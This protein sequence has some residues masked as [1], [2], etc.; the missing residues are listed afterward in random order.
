[1]DN[2]YNEILQAG[3]ELATLAGGCFWCMVPPFINLPGV[4]KVVSGYTG[5]DKENPTYKEVCNGATGHLEAIQ[6]TFE[7]Q[8]IG[9]EKL[10]EI[11]WK[12]ID[13]T[14]A[15]GQ[16]AD[17]GRSYRTAIFYHNESQRLAAEASKEAINQSHRFSAP[18][19][20]LI[21]P[22]RT[23][24]SAEDYH[25]DYFKKNPVHYKKY[26][27]GSGREAFINFQWAENTSSPDPASMKDLA[28]RLSKIQFDVTQNNATEPPFRNEYWDNKR[29]GIYVDVVS[30]QVLFSSLNKYDS[31][32]GWPSFTRPLKEDYVVEKSDLS[33]GMRRIEV[34]S[35]Q[36][37]SHLGHVFND[38]PDPSGL[39]YCINSAALRFIPLEEM[40]AFG[41]GDYL[42][43]FEE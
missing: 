28:K 39:R 21:L 43:I 1:M 29:A 2:Q 3:E 13:P 17:R 11:F 7:P 10:L 25:Q 27:T 12:Q 36:A 16:F 23:F 6:L 15:G 31:G 34:K 41:Y 37:D 40:K 33:Q 5:G 30:G 38:G 19:A 24:Y 26:R 22:A 14:D 4:I 9:Y 32:C 18:V 42:H 20:T 8:T 35:Q